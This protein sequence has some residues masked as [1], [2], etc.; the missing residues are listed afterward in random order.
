MTASSMTILNCLLSNRATHTVLFAGLDEELFVGPVNTDT[1]EAILLGFYVVHDKLMW[2]CTD[3]R[4][5][6]SISDEECSPVRTD[7]D[8]DLQIRRD[9]NFKFAVPLI[10]RYTNGNVIL[11]PKKVNRSSR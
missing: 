2:A 7:V 4:S 6:V 11:P 9:N 3:P 1:S 8:I 10:H 5:P